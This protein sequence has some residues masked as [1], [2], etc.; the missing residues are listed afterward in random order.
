MIDID[1]VMPLVEATPG[2]SSD[3]SDTGFA[4][5]LAAV[6]GSAAEG[7]STEAAP[8]TAVAGTMDEN[9]G[10][11]T[12][13]LALVV[14]SQRSEVAPVTP[15]VETELL[16][17]AA[18]ATESIENDLPLTVG[19]SS[20]EPPAAA[21]P[22]DMATPVVSDQTMPAVTAPV[23][24]AAGHNPA[25]ETLP[26]EQ[27]DQATV[28]AA[29]ELEA[30]MVPEQSDAAFTA[31]V[32]AAGNPTVQLVNSEAPSAIPETG[33]KLEAPATTPVADTPTTTPPTEITTNT[34]AATPVA[35]TPTATPPTEITTN[36]PADA[37]S[38]EIPEDVAVSMAQDAPVDVGLSAAQPG[39]D[40]TAQPVS[41]PT[42]APVESL[43]PAALRTPTVDAVTAAE[44]AETPQPTR[45]PQPASPA[46]QV[47]EALQA[48]RRMTDGSHRLSLQLYPE[49]LGAIQLEVAAREGQLH[50]RA[51]AE[52]EATRGLLNASL[53]ELR[54]SLADAG[55]SAGS[56]EVGAE[57]SGRQNA[58]REQR[59]NGSRPASATQSE[60]TTA[61]D[62]PSQTVTAPGR[63]DVRL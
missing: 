18:D 61:G 20:V 54:S 34:P 36:T 47:A 15:T 8:D 60:P 51:V 13:L 56:L 38:V 14:Q 29:S 23:V 37:V 42:T 10:D 21:A 6:A 22:A 43:D 53:G 30:S 48:V 31:V 2:R 55:V 45:A 33:I 25:D 27:P 35:D 44:A 39:A 16:D 1:A 49:E 57:T 19:V 41:V 12:N 9:A 28:A 11:V 58:E 24:A 32:A 50:V 46:Q 63:V 3:P 17:E 7:E 5:A 40:R 62:T 59:A 4:D 52:T 26:V